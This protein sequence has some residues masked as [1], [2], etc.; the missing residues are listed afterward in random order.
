MSY[1]AES[2]ATAANTANTASNVTGAASA[3]NTAG[4][5]S[6]AL[7]FGSGLDIGAAG[8]YSLMA[9]AGSQAPATGYSLGTTPLNTAGETNWISSVMDYMRQMDEGPKM[10]IGQA[11]DEA[12]VNGL[13]A[14]TLGYAKGKLEGF[15]DSGNGNSAPA[16]T[17]INN[18]YEQPEDTYLKRYARR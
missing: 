14:K 11:Y 18:R 17:I 10:N 9:D 1:G 13:S 3:L 15:L 2:A 7:N 16:P 6:G 8:N 4:G 12:K 5:A